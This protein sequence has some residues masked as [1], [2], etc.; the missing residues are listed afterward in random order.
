MM[1]EQSIAH[2]KVISKLGEG[3]MGAVYRAT[4]T[5]L[6]RE[7]AV[8]ILPDSFAGDPGRLARFTRE[9]QVLAYLNHPNI[10]QIYVVEDRALVMELVEGASL[11]GPLSVEQA[12][13]LIHQ[14]IDALEYAHEKGVVHHDLKPANI[15]V[16]RDGRLQVLDFG[17]AKALATDAAAGNPASSPTLTLRATMAGVI[18]GAVAYMSPEQARGH[19][20]DHRADIWA[21]GAIVY[22]MLTGRQ[23]CQGPTV[24]QTLASAPRREI[25]HAAVPARFRLLLRAC[26]HR[27]A[28]RRLRDIGDARILLAEAPVLHPMVPVSVDMGAGSV[29]ISADGTRV[30]YRFP[31]PSGTAMLATRLLDQAKDTVLS[32]TGGAEQ[33]FFKPD[34]PWIGFFADAKMQNISVLGGEAVTLCDTRSSPRGASWG[35]DGAITP[36]RNGGGTRMQ[37]DCAVTADGRKF[38]IDAQALKPDAPARTADP[39]TL[40]LNWSAG[41]KI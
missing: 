27:E 36:F 18:M 19:D 24:S 31:G 2:Y 35:D 11:A 32:G 21:F 40:M 3:G 30:P 22:E 15:L 34:G 28:R 13:P 20:V 37:T 38:L 29:A 17:L 5:K 25:D 10:A 4:D 6:N 23:M 39:I 8:K 9:A 14:L 16:T 1:P 7:V 26:L 33:P 12:L 41:L